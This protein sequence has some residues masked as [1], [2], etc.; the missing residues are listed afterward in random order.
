LLAA[1]LPLQILKKAEGWVYHICLVNNFKL[2]PNLRLVLSFP[3]NMPAK[4]TL[5]AQT[6]YLYHFMLTSYRP[7]LIHQRPEKIQRFGDSD[8]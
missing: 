8:S 3:T 6:D 7:V 4:C 2:L 5:T 1:A